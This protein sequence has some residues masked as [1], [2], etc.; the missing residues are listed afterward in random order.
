MP[1]IT[2]GDDTKLKLKVPSKGDTNWSQDFKT[3]FAQKI[4]DHDHT[5][6]DGKGAK[7]SEAAIED[8]AITTDKIA[9]G[10]I[11]SVKI[12]A[13]AVADIDLAP[14][15][16]GTSELKNDAVETAN[17]LDANVTEAK[18]ATNSVS[19]LKIVDSNVTTAKIADANV[20]AAKIGSDVVLSTLNDVSSST[21]SAGQVLKW[22]GVNNQWA[23]GT[24]SGAG[25]SGV[26]VVSS[27]ADAANYTGTSRIIH[28]TAT[29]N[30]T[31]TTDLTNKIIFWDQPYKLTFSDANLL[32]C[33]LFLGNDAAYT[34]L[35][36]ENTS[37]DGSTD[38]RIKNC[39][40]RAWCDAEID[41]VGDTTG[42]II[43]FAACDIV[44]G[45]T[46]DILN[47]NNSYTYISSGTFSAW[48][49]DSSTS[50]NARS[51]EFASIVVKLTWLKGILST[52][53]YANISIA[54]GS[55]STNI[56]INRSGSTVI[57]PLIFQHPFKVING[58][59]I[60]E[61]HT[62]A[63]ITAPPQAPVTS[64]TDVEN[65]SIE[66]NKSSACAPSLFSISS[67]GGSTN[68][69]INFVK[70][71]KYKVEVWTTGSYS[72]ASYIPSG[73][74]TIIY[75]TT[76][77]TSLPS[78]NTWFYNGSGSS[79]IA[80]GRPGPHSSGVVTTSMSSTFEVTNTSTNYLYLQRDDV[81][82]STL[83]LKITLIE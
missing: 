47:A 1:L 62:V 68:N 24:D 3:E 8:G 44:I 32:N 40:I 65:L 63:S 76:T 7:I 42:N 19:T 66:S 14:D 55:S 27:A 23:P 34:G 11:T 18:L 33:S 59:F 26:D 78:I 61:G 54:N 28:I 56:T 77:G 13:D 16:V 70:T 35:R 57:G 83:K 21:P 39:T 73:T 45:G 74:S 9:D 58:K 46:V 60:P 10:A 69:R 20:T 6:V 37:T 38:V 50:T 12:A 80:I 71:G 41:L 53:N 36:F 82:L 81:Q 49:V 2:L 79:T 31:F 72:A 52:D 22:D 67:A 4:V 17:I 5:G 75:G 43:N 25:G 15:S 29:E 30:V 48:Q 64:A 51:I